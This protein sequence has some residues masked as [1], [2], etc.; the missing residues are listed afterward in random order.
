M[1]SNAG[2]D[3]NDVSSLLGVSNTDGRTPVAIY[4]DPVTHRL[5]VDGAGATG[6]NGATGVTGPTG[7]TG[8]GVTGATGTT[9]VTGP[10]GATGAT[11]SQGPQGTAGTNAT[12][13]GATGVTGVTGATGPTGPQGT[14]GTNAILTGP[15]GL[16]GAT[17]PTGPQGTA[18]TN[19]TLTGAT[20]PTGLTGVT[21]PTGTNGVTGPTGPTGVPTYVA[22][23]YTPTVTLV[24]GAGNTVPVYTTNTGN[25]TQIGNRVFVDVYL[26]GDGGA[27]GAG[28]G[29]M[30]IALPVAMSSMPG[31]DLPVGIALNNATY[32]QLLAD[33]G[34]GGSTIALQ[35]WTSVSA[36]ANFT[37]ADQNNTT[38][39][40]RLQ[41]SYT[42]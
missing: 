21:G 31:N 36:I 26:T 11:G 17:G 32:Y 24:G 37:G 1:A 7:P 6:A 5:L 8:A 39:L 30:T 22:T 27:E 12:L 2:K 19:A 4:A 20:G 15:T 35:Y 16:T 14:A 38:R 13:T 18:G 40:I 25:Y 3:E 29:I 9:G 33:W 42:A 34:G 41:F 28:T 10:T 23:T